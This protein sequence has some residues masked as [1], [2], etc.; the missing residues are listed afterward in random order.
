[1]KKDESLL[2]FS[3]EDTQFLDEASKFI[4]DPGAIA[5]GLNALGKP[6]EWTS[7]LLSEK[8]KI[9]IGKATN[10]ALK[11]ALAAAVATIP[12][13]K[14]QVMNNDSDST[15]S[16]WLH[17]G[18]TILTGAVSGFFGLPALI[19]ELPVTTVLILRGIM[20]QAKSFGHNI[21]DPE[22]QL[23]CLMVF[24]LGSQGSEDDQIESSYFSTR[25]MYMQTIK[26]ASKLVA[27]QSAKQLLE[28]IE[29]GSAPA[30]LQLI[31]KIAEAFEIRV[32][33]KFLGEMVPVVGAIG[34]AALNY[35]FTD[36]YCSAAKYHFG[37]RALE[38]KYGTESIQD[39][40]KIKIREFS[41]I[42]VTGSAGAS[43]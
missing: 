37:V 31:A 1:M 26:E 5:K 41:S 3:P 38:Q 22:I 35:A 23:E 33:Q 39:Y 8:V 6:L 17:K 34:G 27:G 9:A 19:V 32:T 21:E 7:N 13:E 14:V 2:L 43:G 29:K 4:A 12:M 30:L 25:L 16:S 28:S 24:S 10:G 20:D 40:M 18:S 36:L 15:K 11:K 42:R